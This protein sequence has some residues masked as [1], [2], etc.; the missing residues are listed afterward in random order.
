MPK[1][2]CYVCLKMLVWRN[3]SSKIPDFYLQSV[4]DMNKGG[5]NKVWT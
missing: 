4:E 5:Q 1:N 2:L 3:L